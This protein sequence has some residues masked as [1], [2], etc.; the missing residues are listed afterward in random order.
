MRYQLEYEISR[1]AGLS[2]AERRT[3]LD[4]AVAAQARN[5]RNSA[6]RWRPWLQDHDPL[7]MAA[8]VRVP[9][10]IL[11]GLT[12]RA[13]PP[14]DADTLAAVMRRAGNTRVRVEFFPALNH[15][16]QVDPIGARDGY[17]SLPV[18]TL[19]DDFLRVLA[20]WLRE[21]IGPL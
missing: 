19:A 4:D 6:E 15:H 7:P 16:F 3:A 10:L 18:Q 21:T 20:S 12:D 9:V 8:Q 5:A 11:H 13:V 17:A 1:N 2:P 14:S